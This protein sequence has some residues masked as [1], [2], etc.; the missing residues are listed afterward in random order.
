M[1]IIAAKDE[2]DLGRRAANL[3]G[4]E[5]LLKPDCTLGLATGSTPLSTYAELVSRYGRG[6][7]DFS[8]VHSINLDEYAGL[9]GEHPQ[10]YRYFMNT[11]LF[12]KINIDLNNT[13]V[14]DGQAKDPAAEC[15][16]YDARIAAVPGGID[17]Q[18]LGIGPNGHIGF[19]EPGEAF[20]PGT[21]VVTLTERTRQA[22]A[23]FFDS[24]DEVPTKAVTMGMRGIMGAKKVLLIAEGSAKAKA[25]YD[26]I[27]GPVTPKVPASILQ[28]HQD[29]TVI[30]DE[31]ALSLVRERTGWTGEKLERR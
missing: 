8:R 4:A 27:F 19:N 17:L 14:P 10:S 13:H 1:R 21:H 7:L 28:L 23:R 20:I 11:N 3:I 6:E 22:N 15:A 16:R 26:A 2:Q 25:L 12:S 9:S 30:A 31:A 18:L 29:C 24:I 5:V